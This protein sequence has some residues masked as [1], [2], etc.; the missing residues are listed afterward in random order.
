[1]REAVFAE[2]ILS[3]VMTPERAASVIGDLEE[4]R[5]LHGRVWFWWSVFGTAAACLVGDLSK[6]PLTTVCL[7]VWASVA[8]LVG[9]SATPLGLMSLEWRL[10]ISSVLFSADLGIVIIFGV[11]PLAIGW[12]VAKSSRGRETACGLAA[13]VAISYPIHRFYGPGALP[14]QLVS[15]LFVLAGSILYRI[16]M[17]RS[18]VPL[19]S[20]R[21]WLRRVLSKPSRRPLASPPAR[22]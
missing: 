15:A 20:R 6:E 8:E 11:L 13:A 7:A 14:L 21:V 4:Q 18:T 16:I 17:R 22:R 3:L 10:H 9:L 2:W 5:P 19:V 1:M 12:G